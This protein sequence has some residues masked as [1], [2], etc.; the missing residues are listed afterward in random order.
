MQEVIR[1]ING[2]LQTRIPRLSIDDME[3]TKEKLLKDIEKSFLG[4][5]EFCFG[6]FKTIFG[7]RKRL[8]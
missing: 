5:T 8:F 3:V 6:L 1:A 2:T 7:I 4:S